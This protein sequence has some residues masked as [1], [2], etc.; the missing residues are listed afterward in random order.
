MDTSKLN[1]EVSPSVASMA[2]SSSATASASTSS[3]IEDDESAS[4][5]LGL[6]QLPADVTVELYQCPVCRLNDAGKETLFAVEAKLTTH[7]DAHVGRGDIVRHHIIGEGEDSTPCQRP[8]LD[9]SG[10]RILCDRWFMVQLFSNGT[11]YG[12]L[13]WRARQAVLAAVTEGTVTAEATSPSK[14]TFSVTISPGPSDAKQQTVQQRQQQLQSQPPPP[15]LQ[16]PSSSSSSNSEDTND[17]DKNISLD[18][19]H[20]V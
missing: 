3:S 8:C 7:L 10:E 11:G 14:S 1:G 15:P 16:L 17:Q 12:K 6:S 20:Q 5:K 9:E 2:T 13:K 19:P 4:I 18:W